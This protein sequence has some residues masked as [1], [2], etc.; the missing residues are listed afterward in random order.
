MPGRCAGCGKRDVSVRKIQAHVV[1]CPSFAALYR[2]DPERALDPEAEEERWQRTEGSE[3]ARIAARD[4]R[5][6][7]LR[8]R[9]AR[10]RLDQADRWRTPKGLLD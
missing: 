1:Q 10:Q 3:E 2:T 9:L 7:A 8:A 6:E 5:L 4:E